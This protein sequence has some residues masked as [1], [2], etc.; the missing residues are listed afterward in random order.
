MTIDFKKFSDEG[1]NIIIANEAFDN[2]RWDFNIATGLYDM[3][4]V[5]RP[6]V[7][8]MLRLPRWSHMRSV[9]G[10]LTKPEA[11]NSVTKGEDA[12][13]AEFVC[14]RLHGYEHAQQIYM[15]T[16]LKL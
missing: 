14:R 5:A 7:F 15:W 13:F 9:Y 2:A 3:S 4:P 10:Q 12:D 11:A 16:S 8:C 6:E 1:R